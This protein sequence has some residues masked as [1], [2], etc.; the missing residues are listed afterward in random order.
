LSFQKVDKF[1]KQLTVSKKSME[2]VPIGDSNEENAYNH[3]DFIQGKDIKK[4]FYNDLLD[5]LESD[6][7][8]S[9]K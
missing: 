1:Y 4:I 6:K 8:T 2:S 7:L 9:K 3:V 5:I